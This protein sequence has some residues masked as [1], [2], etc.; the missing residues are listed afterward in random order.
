MVQ[1][2][3]QRCVKLVSHVVVEIGQQ[4]QA[5]DLANRGMLRQKLKEGMKGEELLGKY[6]ESTVIQPCHQIDIAKCK[7]WW[8]SFVFY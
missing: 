8:K 2:P 6:E 4:T 1:G 7:F 3:I 5:T